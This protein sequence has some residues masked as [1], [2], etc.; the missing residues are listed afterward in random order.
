MTIF[1]LIH[2]KQMCNICDYIYGVEG[3][4]MS[5]TFLNNCCRGYDFVITA[6]L[7]TVVVA[8]RGMLLIKY[9]CSSKL[10]CSS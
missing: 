7:I 4:Q 8:S 6:G 1:T 3:L 2:D 9:F 5:L 10:S